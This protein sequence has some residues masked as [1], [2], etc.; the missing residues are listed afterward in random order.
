MPTEISRENLEQ[1]QERYR[2]LQAEIGKRIVGYQNVIDQVLTAMFAGGHVLLEGVPG[3]GKTLTVR[4][5]SDA[6]QLSFRRIQFTPDLMPADITGTNII[7]EDDS[8]ARAFRFQPGPIFAHLVLADEINRATPKT[9]S[10]I[11][12]AMQ[13]HSVTIGGTTPRP[14]RPVL[15]PGDAEP[16][17]D[18]RDLSAP[19]GAGRPLL[20]QGRRPPTGRGRTARHHRPHHRRRGGRDRPGARSR[21]NRR[22]AAHRPPGAR[23]RVRAA[24]R[25]PA[26][27]SAPT[28]TASTRPT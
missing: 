16:D 24:L 3:L 26:S 2:R 4:T 7:H 6:T 20:L 9:Q 1:F 21:G 13:E 27:H 8:G 14:A 17:R 28:P 25:R 22:D 5:I 23:R 10:A 15:G 11:L 12:E 18:G 19:G